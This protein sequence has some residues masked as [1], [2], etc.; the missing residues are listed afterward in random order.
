MTMKQIK[1]YFKGVF[2]GLFPNYAT[3]KKLSS[4][5]G[6]LKFKDAPVIIPPT[7]TITLMVTD[8]V[9][10][11]YVECDGSI[12]NISD[13]RK[14]AGYIKNKFGSYNYFGG[15]GT[16]TFGIPDNILNPEIQD[17]KALIKT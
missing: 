2:S 12:L 9:P 15:N 3:I 10:E 5:D 11:G 7:G 1:A 4:E 14:L 6:V 8:T 17:V 16:T 13:Y